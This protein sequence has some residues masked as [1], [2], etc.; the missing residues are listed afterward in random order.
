MQSVLDDTNKRMVETHPLVQTHTTDRWPGWRSAGEVLYAE[1]TKL[2]TARFNWWLL[3]GAV[4]VTVAV[5]A[6]CDAVVT[7]TP[8]I[9]ACQQD[10]T[11]LSLSGI[12]FGG[13]ILV[14]VLAV[15]A[16]SEEYETGMIRA[17]LTAMPRRTMVF[18]AKA[19]LL[20]GVVTIA[21]VASV[22]GSVLVGR[23]I[24]PSS[25]FTIANGFAP[26][27]LGDSATLR[28]AVGSVL[29]LCLIALLGLG[30]ATALRNTAATVSSA[31][32]LIYLFP[33]FA[34]VAGSTTWQRRYEA[35]GPMPA[36][37]A[38]Q[39]TKDLGTM[40]IQPWPG[41]GVLAAWAAGAMLIGWFVLKRRDA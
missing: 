20:V 19:T 9:A 2:R 28:A 32:G 17:T 21:G 3:A 35:I 33:L 13:Q 31:L 38:I 7:C 11:R 37:L 18:A 10:T 22:G 16:I 15:L 5:S 8:S 4:L 30:I 14:A 12:G 24:L 1:Y 25:G 6:A 40:P 27:S 26:L 36:G 29:Y 39:A 41:L 23:L 34:Q